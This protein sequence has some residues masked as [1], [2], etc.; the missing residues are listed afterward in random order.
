VS[1]P[2]YLFILLSSSSV[3]T[4]VVGVFVSILF[5]FPVAGYLI[6][7]VV[8]A[9]LIFSISLDFTGTSSNE[10][11]ILTGKGFVSVVC[12]VLREGGLGAL[13]RISLLV[14][15]QLL[16]QWTVGVGREPPRRHLWESGF[17]ST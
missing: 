16:Q 8:T 13:S 2:A 1:D 12:F 3:N 14:E 7:V 11:H 9:P 5:S 10:L 17:S 15:M 6:Y 4:P